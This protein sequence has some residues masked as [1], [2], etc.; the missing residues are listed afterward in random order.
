MA[1][2]LLF[3]TCM[4][5]A[6]ALSQGQQYVVSQGDLAFYRIR[7]TGAMTNTNVKA[8][9]E[10]AGMSFPCY[11]SNDACQS[12]VHWTSVCVSYNAVDGECRTPFVLANALCGASPDH[13]ASCRPLDDIFVYYPYRAY[14]D[15]AWG[16]DYDTTTYGLNGEN[17]NDKFALCTDF[18]NCASSPCQ[19]GGTCEDRLYGY[20]CH[21]SNYDETFIDVCESDPC[22]NGGT[23]HSH[24]QGQIF[25][26]VCPYGFV[27]HVC[28]TVFD[29]CDPNPCPFDWPCIAAFT[30]W[31]A[32]HCNVPTAQR[33]SSYCGDF[34]CGAGWNCREDGP[35][36]FSCIRG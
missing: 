4:I 8:T 10:A 19:P 35:T 17:F 2:I 7:A 21:Y 18:D 33:K 5:E 36:G 30:Y 24:N 9:C 13:G 28:E 23:C 20:S 31:P 15:S 12:G 3:I 11:Y 29:P 34:P 32:A 22:Q 1:K 16:T 14:G 26:C 6:V 27:G 25:H